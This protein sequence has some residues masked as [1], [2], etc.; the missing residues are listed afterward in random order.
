LGPSFFS[1]LDKTLPLK[2]MGW[3]HCLHIVA[4]KPCKYHC[5]HFEWHFLCWPVLCT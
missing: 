5:N 2:E 1:E 4:K 3:A